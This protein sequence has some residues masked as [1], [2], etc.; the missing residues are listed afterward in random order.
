MNVPHDVTTAGKAFHRLSTK[1]C[2][3]SKGKG[4]STFVTLCTIVLV[5]QSFSVT[6][7]RG[8]SG[9]NGQNQINSAINNFANLNFHSSFFNIS[10]LDIE[11]TFGEH[12]MTLTLFGMGPNENIV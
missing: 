9:H 2:H 5:I 8:Q 11:W 12:L 3:S 6:K 1:L 4:V 10:E 7:G